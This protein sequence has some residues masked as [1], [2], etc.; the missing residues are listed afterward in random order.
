M[1]SNIPDDF[2]DWTW[3]ISHEDLSS[4]PY[5]PSLMMAFNSLVEAFRQSDPN[6]VFSEETSEALQDGGLL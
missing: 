2:G 5:W 3:V 4:K 6:S 1:T